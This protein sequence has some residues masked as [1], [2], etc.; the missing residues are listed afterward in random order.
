MLLE[1][2]WDLSL[3]QKRRME[4]EQHLCL[5]QKRHMERNGTCLWT[6]NGAWAQELVFGTETVHVVGI[7]MG[8]VFGPETAHENRTALVFGPEMA[9]ENRT[10]LVF[11]PET[12]HENR[13]A[14]VFGPETAHGNGTA[15]V[16]GP[17]MAH[18][19]R[20][21]WNRNSACCWNGNGTCLWT[22]NGTWKRNG[23]CL[24][25]GNSTWNGTALVF[26]PA[27][28]HNLYLEWKQHML[29]E[30]EWDL[31]LEQK[32]HLGSPMP[33]NGTCAQKWQ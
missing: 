8:L 22:G 5:D 4:M 25:T 13:T 19:H 30:Q 28:V 11:G 16:F 12:A 14:L 2:E 17:E 20:N 29:L 7:G 26:G 9:H 1:W 24:W 31:C 33:R 18:R 23:I 6:G 21:F 27:P 10:A 32:R 3:D 15:L